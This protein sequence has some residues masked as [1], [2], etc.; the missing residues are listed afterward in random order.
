[1]ENRLEDDNYGRKEKDNEIYF[2]I[3]SKELPEDTSEMLFWSYNGVAEVLSSKI[4]F[5][6]VIREDRIV[7]DSGEGFKIRVFNKQNS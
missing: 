5:K 1:M 2:Y 6:V 7:A 3:D 4:G